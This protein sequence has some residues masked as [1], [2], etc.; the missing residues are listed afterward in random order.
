MH[1]APSH[2]RCPSLVI[3]SS[4]PYGVILR[5]VILSSASS[6]RVSKDEGRATVVKPRYGAAE[7]FDGGLQSCRGGRHW[8]HDERAP[9]GVR[10]SERP[11][12][13]S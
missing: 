5:F 3:L 10:V 8:Y 1:T 12:V 6:M 13:S 9:A 4:A 2:L 7:R 11:M